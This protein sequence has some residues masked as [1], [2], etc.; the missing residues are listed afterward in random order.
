MMS[1]GDEHLKRA[2]GFWKV[3]REED[4]QGVFLDVILGNLA[5]G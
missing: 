3:G 4:G 5:C 1:L 2:Q